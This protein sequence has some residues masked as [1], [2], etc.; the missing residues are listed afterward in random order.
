MGTRFSKQESDTI[1]ERFSI[2]GA[3]SLS[4]LL[5][6]SKESIRKWANRRGLKDPNWNLRYRLSPRKCLRKDY[7]ETWTSSM[8]YD[9]GYITADGTIQTSGLKLAC[10][11]SDREILVGFKERLRSH[12]SLRDVVS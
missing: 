1:I 7:F 10:E 4:S 2:D 5:G 3:G 11:Q 8:A 9:L 6:K 12:H